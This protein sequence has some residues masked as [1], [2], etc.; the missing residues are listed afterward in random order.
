MVSFLIVSLGHLSVIMQALSM[1]PILTAETLLNFDESARIYE[2]KL[3]SIA[4]LLSVAS[5]ISGVVNPCFSLT[6]FVPIKDFVNE[7]FWRFDAA[8]RPIIAS[9]D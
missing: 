8:T 3:F 9:V 4:M 1:E 7:Y 5:S 6:P 2:T